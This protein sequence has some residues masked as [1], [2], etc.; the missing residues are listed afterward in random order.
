MLLS[1]HKFAQCVTTSFKISFTQI[2]I[3]KPLLLPI[4]G[5]E[6]AVLAVTT[7]P[8]FIIYQKKSMP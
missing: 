5:T 2:L 7:A 1:P 3:C 4:V 6:L 8:T